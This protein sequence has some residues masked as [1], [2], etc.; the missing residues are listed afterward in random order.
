[1]VNCK[2]CSSKNPDDERSY[3][4]YGQDFGDG[5]DHWDSYIPLVAA[6]HNNTWSERIKMTPNEAYC[7]RKIRLPVDANAEQVHD[8]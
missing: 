1:M 2:G 8:Q 5:G 7:G 3:T 6:S 4:E